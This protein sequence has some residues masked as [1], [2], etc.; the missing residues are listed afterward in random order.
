MVVLGS[1][2]E[3]GGV[4]RLRMGSTCRVGNDIGVY[5]VT[6]TAVSRSYNISRKC[7]DGI[8]YYLA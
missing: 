5:E 6:R 1:A 3:C 8:E 2:E 4:T 7:A